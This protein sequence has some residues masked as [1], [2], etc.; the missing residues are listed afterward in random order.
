[1]SSTSFGGPE[2][3]PTSWIESKLCLA[4]HS[5]YPTQQSNDD[6]KTFWRH[7]A[8]DRGIV[9]I[10]E[11]VKVLHSEPKKKALLTL[12][13]L[14][15]IADVKFPTRWATFRLLGFEGVHVN[16]KTGKESLE[17]ALALVLGDIHSTPPQVRIHSQCITGEVFHSLRCDCHDQ[18]QLALR[19]IAE[20]GAGVL[21]YEQQEGR[22][23]GLME[24]LRAYELQDEGFDTVE[25]NLRLGH[26]VDARDY[27]LAGQ[28]LHFLEIHSLRLISNNPEKM[29]AVLSAGIH[30]VERISA[31][32]HASAYSSR[33]LA[34]KREKLGHFSNTSSPIVRANQSAHDANLPKAG[35][36]AAGSSDAI[37]ADLRGGAWQMS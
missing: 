28:I 34:T 21:I 27:V 15:Q 3:H 30:I 35:G 4:Q 22:G 7:R 12:M 9:F 23:I 20:G 1:M 26:A 8:G 13:T 5:S 25:A 11:F 10:Y 6:N 18:L 31:D 19:A 2:H 24:K 14:K 32:V 37:C 29:K 36:E 17:T 16:K 33:Y